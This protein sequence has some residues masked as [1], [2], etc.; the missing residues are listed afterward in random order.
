MGRA[1]LTVTKPDNIRV[2]DVICYKAEV[3]DRTQSTPFVNEFC[4]KVDAFDN[5]NKGDKG[6]RKKPRDENKQDNNVNKQGGFSLPNIIECRKSQSDYKFKEDEEGALIVKDSGENSYDFFVNMD[7]LSLKT[8]MKGYSKID[9][10][11][12]EAR[13]KIGMVLLGLSIVNT[14]EKQSDKNKEKYEN[15][16]SIYDKIYFFTKSISPIFLTMISDLGSLEEENN[17]N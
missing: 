12:L 14:F 8:D 1:T 11:I 6:H 7:N 16:E 9:P 2:G 4:I 13:F 10:K 5:E 3:I 17:Y 15:G